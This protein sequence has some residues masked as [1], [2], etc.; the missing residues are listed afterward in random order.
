MDKTNQPSPQEPQKQE[1]G[2]WKE[3]ADYLQVTVHTAQKWE[4]ERNLPVHRIPGGMERVY[5]LAAELEAWKQTALQNANTHN[6][7]TGIS[8][9][10]D[11][12][13][14]RE[15]APRGS[16]TK[17]LFLMLLVAL[18]VAGAPAIYFF[19]LLLNRT[20]LKRPEQPALW[21]VQLNTL[22]VM[23]AKG[24]ELWRKT[25][26]EETQQAFYDESNKFRQNM[27][28]FRDL[29]GDGETE[30]LFN[31][32]FSRGGGELGEL[33]CLSKKGLEKWRFVPGRP[34]STHRGSFPNAFA[35]LNFTVANLGGEYPR[36][37]IVAARHNPHYPCQVA[38]LS[39]RGEL[40]RE[41][42][43]SGHIGLPMC[44]QVADLNKDGHFEI[45]LGGVNNGYGQAT[46][47]ALDPRTM[48]GASVE[49]NRDFQLTGF[50]PGRELARILLPRSCMSEQASVYNFV[51]QVSVGPSSLTLHVSEAM[52]SPHPVVYYD[53]D[54]RFRLLSFRVSDL[55]RSVHRQMFQT[56]QLD[57]GWSAT[58]EAAMHNIR[59]LPLP[60][61]SIADSPPGKNLSP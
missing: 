41:Y 30:T 40:Y 60:S 59:V 52:Q 28:L 56:G 26:T 11:S 24:R 48:G 42:W 32:N 25:F 34:V 39:P 2:S 27:V 36:S 46:L 53:L 23:D 3:I 21:R 8:G 6:G 44:M 33:V 22:I 13:G 4:H 38:L 55:F 19:F 61:A 51:H 12:R 15:T 37:V 10:Q 57:H 5:A 16:S 35:I 14:R 58:E 50:E 31:L 7:V 18:C 49:E 29:D 43:H 9:G 54:A 20:I 1:L 45:Y 17:P 47:I